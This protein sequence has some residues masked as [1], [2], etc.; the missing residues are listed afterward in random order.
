MKIEI[1]DQQYN[2]LMVFLDRVELKGFNEV[3]AFNEIIVA[4]RNPIVEQPNLEPEKQN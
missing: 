4:L 1:T 2:N 3:Q